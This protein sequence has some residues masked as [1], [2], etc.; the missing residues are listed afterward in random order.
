[1]RTSPTLPPRPSPS[2]STFGSPW[3]MTVV[4]LFVTSLITANLVAVKVL[5]IGPWV[6]DAG[7]ID[8][9]LE[10]EGDIGETRESVVE[11][12]NSNQL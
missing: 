6:T 3:F 7:L 10:E 4:A 8:R 12:M 1:M 11:G 2:V 9:V 5:E